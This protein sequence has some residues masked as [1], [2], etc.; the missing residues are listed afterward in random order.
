M[1]IML[2]TLAFALSYGQPRPASETASE[3]INRIASTYP[4]IKLWLAICGLVIAA[5]VAL[6]THSSMQLEE[7]FGFR[8]ILIALL[9]LLGPIIWVSQ[10]ELYVEY[11]QDDRET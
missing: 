5:T 8:I 6:V 10:H 9:A 7:I 3:R 11:G 1:W 2:G 4:F